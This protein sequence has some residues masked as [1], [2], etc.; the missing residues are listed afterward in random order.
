MEKFK[1][2]GQEFIQLNQLIKH[3][4]W[5]ATGG[6][7]NLR[8]DSSEVRVNGEI[9]LRRRNKLKAGFIVEFGKEKVQIL[10]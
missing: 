10:E 7:A 1:L 6:E 3:L 2:N 5:V 4:G 8:I 9:E